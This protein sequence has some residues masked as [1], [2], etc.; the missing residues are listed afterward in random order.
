MKQWIRLILTSGL[1]VVCLASDESWPVHKEDT[2]NRTIAF[3]ATPARLVIENIEGYVHVKA[4]S[5][6]DVRVTAHRTVRAE[7]QRDVE[8]ALQEV[9][10]EMSE[11]AGTASITYEAPWVCRGHNSDSG[12]GNC[13]DRGRRFYR[14]AFDIEVEVPANVRPYISTV[15]HGD[16]LLEGTT[17]NFEVRNVNGPIDLNNVAGSGTVRTVNGPV[18]A[19]FSKNPAADTDFKTVNGPINVYFPADLSADLRFKTFHGEI[20]SDFDVTPTTVPEGDGERRGTRFVYRSNGMRAARAGQGGPR[21]SFETL[22]GEI[23]LHRAGAA[24][25]SKGEL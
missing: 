7:E 22:N 18:T 24:S 3:S 10:L 12:A 6:S 23:R 21:L 20:F 9:R 13:Q 2:L 8:Q 1:A 11:Q 5:R 15:N 19:R 14:V 4:T 25:G 17:G 16:V